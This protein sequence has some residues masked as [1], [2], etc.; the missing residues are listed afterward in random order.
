M[1]LRFNE[2]A[3]VKLTLFGCATPVTIIGKVA[4]VLP[5]EVEL[6]SQLGVYRKASRDEHN[7]ES[8]D[9]STTADS[10]EHRHV[11]RQLILD[12]CYA[13]VTD[14]DV[15]RN[16]IREGDEPLHHFLFPDEH[17]KPF[18]SYTLNHFDPDGYH[19]GNGPYCGEIKADPSGIA[20]TPPTAAADNEG[21]SLEFTP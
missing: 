13:K 10:D 6:I 16:S 12:W 14:L 19:R 17:K 18:S 5:D 20:F 3:I 21:L 1:N 4:K 2:G 15:S 9:Y 7:F 8:L 11:N